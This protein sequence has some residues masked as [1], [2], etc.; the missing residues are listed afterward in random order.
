LIEKIRFDIQ[1]QGNML[2][3]PEGFFVARSDKWRNQRVLVVIAVPEGKKIKLS[4][5][6][7]DDYDWFNINWSR[8][9]RTKWN[10]DW[11]NGY[12]WEGG[13][14]MI[15]TTDDLK[16]QERIDREAKE[17]LERD[18][19][20]MQDE[21]DDQ[22]N[23]QPKIKPTIKDTSK[24]KSQADTTYRYHAANYKPQAEELDEPIET[25]MNMTGTPLLPSLLQ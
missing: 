15:M 17:K 5:R 1:Q 24:P 21:K 25:G 2:V 7:N 9:H 12:G 13:K 22:N 6:V 18:E 11:T 10:D 3:L 8:R 23:D 19:K 14:E 16:T 4:N 20:K